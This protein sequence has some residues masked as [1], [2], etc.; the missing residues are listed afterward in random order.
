MMTL[1]QWRRANK[2]TQADFAETV[3]ASQSHL[4]E[5]ENK[6]GP[7]LS[8]AARIRDATGGK[9]PLDVWV[10]NDAPKN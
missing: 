3:G 6:G 5:I 4:S 7:S 8:L 1:K 10:E 2:V 9:V